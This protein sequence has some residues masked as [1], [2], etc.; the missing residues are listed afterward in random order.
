MP[1]RSK[2]AV[3]AIL[4]LSQSHQILLFICHPDS[5][6]RVH[7]VDP[8]IPVKTLSDGDIEVT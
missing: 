2:A 4:E 8:S 6:A 1:E 7:E 5:V 3:E